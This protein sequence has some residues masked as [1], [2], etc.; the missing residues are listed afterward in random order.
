LTAAAARH[1]TPFPR[2]SLFLFLFPSAGK[3]YEPGDLSREL[4]QRIKAA[5]A[6]FCGP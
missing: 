1:L 2:A 3:P 5:V 4:D 6:K